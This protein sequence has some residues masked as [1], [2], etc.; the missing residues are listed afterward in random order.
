[1]EKKKCVVL[2]EI[3]QN[4]GILKQPHVWEFQNPSISS[5][6]PALEQEGHF[7][8]LRTGREI[9][10]DENTMAWPVLT[11]TVFVYP[12]G[13]M[14]LLSRRFADGELITL[15]ITK[16]QYHKETMVLHY[17]S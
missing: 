8:E 13:E 14:L 11:G 4:L 10:K 6:T 1:M 7:F 5:V 3:P 12:D 9:Q 2:V 15:P 16:K 17:V